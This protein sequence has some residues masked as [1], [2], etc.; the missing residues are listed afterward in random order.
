MF[1]WLQAQWPE[2]DRRDAGAG[3]IIEDLSFVSPTTGR[4]TPYSLFLPPGY[5]QNP[6]LTYPVVYFLHGYGQSPEDLVLA[7]AVFENYMINPDWEEYQRFQKLII[8]YVDGR[9]RPTM[10]GVPVDPTGDGC[11][12]GTW[13]TDAP[14]GGPAAMETHMFELVDFIDATYRVKPPETL[15]VVP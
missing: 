7:S 13:Y 11:E 14:L 10:S 15:T 4:E 2:G 6:D 1:H 5:E 12:R 3:Q 8:V 9:C